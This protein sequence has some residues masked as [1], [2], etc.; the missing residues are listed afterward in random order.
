MGHALPMRG[1]VRTILSLLSVI[2]LGLL[3]FTLETVA[4]ELGW[5]GAVREFV[6]GETRELSEA[7][8][9]SIVYAAFLVTLGSALT[10]WA[11]YVVRKLFPPKLGKIKETIEGK[12]F[13][14]ERVPIDGR[15]FVKCT[16]D[17]VTLVY[18]GKG[19]FGFDSCQWTPP[20]SIDLLQPSSS[21][22]A[23]LIRLSQQLGLPFDLP[24]ESPASQS[25]HA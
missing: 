9:S 13:R 20:F 2:L 15:R 7:G 3:V 14:H 4:D 6:R 23:K 8:H 1:I 18:E 11:D 17:G 12:L 16:L 24:S 21:E 19:Q 5:V 25:I 10:L 22:V